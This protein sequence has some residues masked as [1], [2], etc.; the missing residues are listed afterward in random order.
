M[1]ANAIVL[2]SPALLEIERDRRNIEESLVAATGERRTRIDD[3][4]RH[5]LLAGGKR[6]RPL[7]SCAVLRA[8]GH[9]PTPFID[10]I[11]AVELA[12]TG[13]LL[14]DDILDGATTRRGLQAAHLAFDVPT[15]ILA[16]D[17]LVVLALE[18]LA[19]GAPPTLIAG[20]C[21]AIKDLCAGESLERER[22]FDA[23]VKIAHC[24]RVNRLKTAA[25]F[26]YAA[27]AG[28]ILGGA[29]ERESDA[30]RAFGSALGDAF[31]M[32]DDLLDFR[33]DAIELGKP[34]GRDLVMGMVTVPLAI[35]L[36]RDP[37]LCEEVRCI[38][39]GAR[40]GDELSPR[41]LRLRDRMVRVGAFAAARRLASE[42]IARALAALDG[43]PSGRWREHLRSLAQAVIQRRR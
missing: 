2:P 18:R 29:E 38:W 22:L 31:Q 7:L 23:S 24:R 17:S 8:L 4:A 40:A 11:I 43:L 33:G 16:G 36:E 26:A 6:V 21:A 32:T 9:D 12:H 37:A 3:A 25:L 5:E 39:D 35:A 19:H 1:K 41:L 30:A 10:F 14:H 27:E 28:A 13:S 34:I 20:L 15:A 42:E